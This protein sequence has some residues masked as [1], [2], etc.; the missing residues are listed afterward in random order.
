MG[1]KEKRKIFLKS[2][3]GTG[4]KMPM[5]HVLKTAKISEKW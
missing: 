1:T 5:I 3:E 2:W 4:G